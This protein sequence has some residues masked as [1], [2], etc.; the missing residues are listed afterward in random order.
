MSI[1]NRDGQ[2]PN[3]TKSHHVIWLLTGNV[4]KNDDH[5]HHTFGL[6]DKQHDV[7]LSHH[8]AIHVLE[9]AK[10]HKSQ[11]LQQDDYW[12]YFFKEAKNWEVLPKCLQSLTIMRQAMKTLE[13]IAKT[14]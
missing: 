1:F 4:F 12:L 7:K 13:T 5:V 8:C 10:W 9:L 11:T 3:R 14:E 2:L 6:W